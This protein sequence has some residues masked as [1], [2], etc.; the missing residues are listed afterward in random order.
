MLASSAV[1]G[2]LPPVEIDGEH[3]L[4]GG[5]VASIPLDRA[6]AR[7]AREVFV[8]QVGRVEQPLVAPTRPWEVALVAF[9]ISRR[10]RFTEAL[11]TVPDGVTVHVLPT[12]E[13]KSFT[14]VSQYRTTGRDAVADRIERSYEASAAY[15]REVRR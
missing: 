13:P 7:G 5:L 11:A 12:G 14:D 9:E 2:L 8:L 10:H 1:P 4:D 3:H 6:I 15:L